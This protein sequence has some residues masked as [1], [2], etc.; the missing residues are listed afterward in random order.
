M[1]HDRP[2][3][4]AE[5]SLVDGPRHAA[6]PVVLFSDS[7]VWEARGSGARVAVPA[8]AV[9]RIDVRDR[10]RARIDGLMLGAAAGVAIAFLHQGLEPLAITGPVY[11]IPG[12]AL[13][14]AV[15]SVTWHT[16]VFLAPS[17]ARTEGMP[18]R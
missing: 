8:S 15:G 17:D 3:S 1:V 4:S 2:G 14:F 12:M 10:A 7:V 11:A 13:G 6:G 16:D 5:L 9:L 18:H